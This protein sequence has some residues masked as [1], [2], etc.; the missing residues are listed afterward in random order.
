MSEEYTYAV[1]RIRA[2]EMKLL[3]KS[4][5]NALLSARDYDECMRLL[6]DHGWG[7]EGKTLSA[8]AL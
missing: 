3:T 8:P 5:L 4:D 2:K 1:A 7:E 6:Y